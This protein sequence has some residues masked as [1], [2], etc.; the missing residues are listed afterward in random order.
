MAAI[1]DA[2]GYVIGDDGDVGYVPPDPVS[3]GGENRDLAQRGEEIT[4][5]RLSY[6]E[7][8][9]AEFQATLN[10]VDD[11]ASMLD[12]LYVDCEDDEMLARIGDQIDAYESRKT[13]FRFAAEAFNAA[14][15]AVNAAGG[16]L[17]M[18]EI[19]PGLGLLPV[20]PLAYMAAI[21]GAVILIDWA[22]NWITVSYNL[23]VEAAK[24]IS[25]PAKRD[26][27]LANISNTAAKQQS[28]GGIGSIATA[29]KWVGIGLLAYVAWQTF[30]KQKD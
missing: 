9:V 28:T 15:Y 18:V 2:N 4:A 27:Q 24:T 5:N 20:V 17:P 22:H 7:Q 21:T 1:Y 23:A 6:I 16:K 14:A 25:D 13:A 29:V 12:Q 26:A 3:W 11:T 30:G 8:K 10:N 19:P